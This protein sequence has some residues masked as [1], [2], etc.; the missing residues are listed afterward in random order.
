[1]MLG[2]LLMAHSIIVG[3]S[4]VKK[5][6]SEMIPFHSAVYYND[7]QDKSYPLE[8]KMDHHRRLSN[9]HSRFQ[10]G[11]LFGSYGSH[12][13]P[14]LFENRFYQ[15]LNLGKNQIKSYSFGENNIP[16]YLINKPLSEIDF[17]F[18][19]NGNEEFK[20]FLS[21]NLTENLNVGIGIRRSSNKG[22]FSNQENLHN[23]VY[24]Q[25]T[26]QKN[27]IRSN[28]E[29]YYNDLTQHENGG[30][31]F[32]IYDSLTASQWQNAVPRLTQAINRMKEFNVSWRNRILISPAIKRDTTLFDTFLLKPIKSSLY[33]DI[34]SSYGSERLSYYD[35]L[36]TSNR[37]FYELYST[38]TSVATLESKLLNYRLQNK[39]ALTYSIPNR[40]SISGYSIIS[41]NALSQR[42]HIDSN[43]KSTNDIIAGLGGTL[44]L[45]LPSNLKL[46]AEI[47][48]P[49]IGYTNSDFLLKG[50]LTKSIQ[51]TEFSF[52]SQYTRQKPGYFNTN[53]YT[54]GFDSIYQLK[55][56]NIFENSLSIKNQSH[57]VSFTAQSFLMEDFL[58]YDSTGQPRQV[59][60]NFI[61]LSASKIW[62]FKFLYLPTS[63]YFQN[64]L[65][66]RAFIRQTIAYRN[67][68]FNDH[69]NLIIGFDI[70]LNLQMPSMMYQPLLTESV[71]NPSTSDSR[72]Y[73][74][75]TF[76]AT[77]K[78][79]KVHL[80]FIIDNFM[81]TYLKNGTNYNQNAPLTPSAFYLRS[82][83]TF[84]E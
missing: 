38:N 75:V 77:L 61:Q 54:S 68:H 49:L 84:L 59:S 6:S 42:I 78:I 52:L 28:V 27:R 64:S 71:Y 32:S 34:N 20:G 19:G 1:M 4:F 66:P 41:N 51:K 39:T 37:T 72:I 45:T 14:F 25:L 55:T 60:N 18:F 76:F 31:T 3:Q 73:P 2:V 50:E 15:N 8:D 36:N 29:F 56:Q 81:S 44:D 13:F 47:Y 62:G 63:I 12:L 9:P 10:D 33:V 5:D 53:M 57:D 69:L 67:K 48:K 11:V 22:F 65:F 17:V 80:S 21:Q 70:L 40:L 26:Y 16:Y 7:N 43:E 79:A 82:T 74:N 46:N 35:V 24:F 58:V 30:M 23:N 83:W